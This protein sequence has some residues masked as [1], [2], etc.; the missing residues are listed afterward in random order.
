MRKKLKC[1]KNLKYLR[2]LLIKNKQ[3]LEDFLS[4]SFIIC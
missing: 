2:D 4:F 1:V 3:F